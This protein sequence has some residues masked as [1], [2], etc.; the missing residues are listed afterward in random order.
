[1]PRIRQSTVT[2]YLSALKQIRFNI[3]EI[4]NVTGHGPSREISPGFPEQEAHPERP[5]LYKPVVRWLPL[6]GVEHD[7]GL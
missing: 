4:C 3:V 6:C 5:Y 1:M 2:K 7:P